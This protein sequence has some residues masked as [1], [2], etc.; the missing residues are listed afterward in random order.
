[1][2]FSKLVHDIKHDLEEL[3]HIVD[4]YKNQRP[5]EPVEE[6]DKEDVRKAVAG[7]QEKWEQFEKGQYEM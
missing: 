7:F 1:M 3:F 2:E 5:G 4:F 6:S